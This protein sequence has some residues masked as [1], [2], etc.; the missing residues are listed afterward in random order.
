LVQYHG[1]GEAATLEPLKDH[2][3]EYEAHLIQNFGSG[4]Q[5]CYRGPRLYDSDETKMMVKRV[6]DWYKKYRAI[7]N[8]DIIH[9]RRPDG[10]D[11]DCMLHV[12]P[13]L[14]EK[15]LAM[16]YNPTDKMIKR[17]ISLPLYYTGLTEAAWIREREGKP[18]KYKLDR[19]YNVQLE[20]IVPARGYNWF[21]IE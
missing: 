19:E 21:V 18:K 16:V 2:L 4:V 3:R 11:L 14:K 17:V 8:S 5:S 9:V 6:V 13:N 7:L 12:N 15:G 10:R 20:V 1:G